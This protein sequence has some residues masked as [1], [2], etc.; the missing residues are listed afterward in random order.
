MLLDK[1]ARK[2][3]QSLTLL[4]LYANRLL[5]RK[6]HALELMER[7]LELMS[8][9]SILKKG[10]AIV[11]KNGKSASAA[12]LNPGDEVKITLVDGVVKAEVINV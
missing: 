7:S 2:L 3:D 11:E 10:Y 9:E 1:Q 5:D 6:L 8:P 4:P 12:S